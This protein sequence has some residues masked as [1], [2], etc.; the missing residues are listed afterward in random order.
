MWPISSRITLHVLRCIPLLGV[1]HGEDRIIASFF[2]IG[3]DDSKLLPSCDQEVPVSLYMFW[4]VYRYLRFH[5]VKAELSQ[6]FLLASMIVSDSLLYWKWFHPECMQLVL[7][8][9]FVLY[10][11][12]T[13]RFSVF[14]LLVTRQRYVYSAISNAG[15]QLALVF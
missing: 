13:S 4:D 9:V 6:F 10:M 7:S 12:N 15:I 5:M 14:R 2:F 1:L 11:L 3:I 8:H